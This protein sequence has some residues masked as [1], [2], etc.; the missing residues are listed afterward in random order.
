M[1]NVIGVAVG[2][3]VALW[4]LPLTAD[5]VVFENRRMTLRIGENA[6]AKS[7]VVKATGEECL[8][9]GADVPLFASMQIRPFNNQTK[10]IHPSKRMT[11][12]ANRLRR[13]G[14]KLIVGFELAPYAAVVKVVCRD[15]YMVF[16][17]EDFISDTV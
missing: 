15:D 9:S 16:T 6:C 14:D 8:Q 4:V 10:L 13:D 3:A 1:R 12:R 2:A 17:L 5:D 11:Y 7:L